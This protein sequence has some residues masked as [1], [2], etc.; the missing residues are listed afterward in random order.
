MSWNYAKWVNLQ[1]GGFKYSSPSVSWWHWLRRSKR[2][3]TQTLF[4]NYDRQYKLKLKWSQYIYWLMFINIY[5]ASVGKSTKG[6]FIS[7][8][9]VWIKYIML[10]QIYLLV[11]LPKLWLSHGWVMTLSHTWE[12]AE[13]WVM[14]LSH[15]WR[16]AESQPRIVDPESWVMTHDSELLQP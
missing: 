4:I 11:N 14:T 15:S 9:G 13:S 8:I 5:W 1:E 7:A 10:G 16:F 3:K 2:W 6:R 12:L